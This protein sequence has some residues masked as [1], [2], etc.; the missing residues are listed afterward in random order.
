MLTGVVNVIFP[1]DSPGTLSLVGDGSNNEVELR[2]IGIPGIP[3]LFRIEGLNGTLLQI[4][5]FDGIMQSLHVNGIDGDVTVN[6][7]TG[8]DKFFLGAADGGR[9][10]RCR[11]V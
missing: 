8:E 9:Y 1:E 3:G 2:S 10:A 6:L 7:G 5:G 11:Q 4:N